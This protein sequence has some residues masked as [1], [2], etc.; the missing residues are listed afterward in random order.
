MLSILVAAIIA[1]IP[2]FC[3]DGHVLIV[4]SAG[5]TEAIVDI[6][7]GAH[8]IPEMS[9]KEKELKPWALQKSTGIE[10]TV[11]RYREAKKFN[12]KQTNQ[13]TNQPINH[14]TEETYP[15]S[16]SYPTRPV[17]ALAATKLLQ[18]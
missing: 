5:S 1:Q 7:D 16:Y 12:N 6:H 15:L 9:V 14:T 18:E 13:P 4:L 8:V 3:S 11:Q 2:A 17:Q 10:P